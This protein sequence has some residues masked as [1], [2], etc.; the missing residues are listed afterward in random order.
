MI[1]SRTAQ[2]YGKEPA[3]RQIQLGLRFP[4]RSEYEVLVRMA[5]R[6]LL[7]AV[8]SGD[9][10]FGR[11]EEALEKATHHAVGPASDASG[12]KPVEVE[13]ETEG[14][15]LTVSIRNHG[16]RF[17]PPDDPVTSP[18]AGGEAQRLLVFL[19]ETADEIELESLADGTRLHL[20]WRIGEGQV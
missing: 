5:A 17:V 6:I 2:V 18:D 14:Q 8:P 4:S 12:N 13:L 16:F 11:I 19:R 10:L 1:D 9:R 20:T 15:R 7:H 3:G